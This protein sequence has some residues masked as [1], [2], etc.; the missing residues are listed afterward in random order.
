MS[1]P[2]EIRSLKTAILTLGFDP[3]L[4]VGSGAPGSFPQLDLAVFE[5]PEEAEHAFAVVHGRAAAEPN[6]NA[7]T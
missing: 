6:G 5:S 3:R 1:E 2:G 7:P 4:S